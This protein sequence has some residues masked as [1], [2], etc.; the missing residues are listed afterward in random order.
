MSRV[1]R[2]VGE[3]GFWVH[4]RCHWL[5]LVLHLDFFNSL[6]ITVDIMLFRTFFFKYNS[7][8]IYLYTLFYMKRF[9]IKLLCLELLKYL[10]GMV[11]PIWF[12]SQ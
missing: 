11:K 6:R 2:W 5:H 1:K 4:T 8:S 10:R 3:G 7:K 9:I 12:Q